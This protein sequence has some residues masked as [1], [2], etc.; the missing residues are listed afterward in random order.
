MNLSFIYI[1]KYEIIDI[2]KSFFTIPAEKTYWEAMVRLGYG[3]KDIII[4]PVTGK[5]IELYFSPDEI[6]NIIGYK[7]SNFSIQRP[8]L[9]SDVENWQF[10]IP[11][12]GR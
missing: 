9:N 12:L 2:L 6:A 11:T 3:F 7:R 10:E 4:D 8:H 1:Y 5:S